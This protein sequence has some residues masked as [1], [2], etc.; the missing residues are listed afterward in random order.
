[1]RPPSLRSLPPF[2]RSVARR[3][4]LS[5]GVV[6]IDGTKVH[7]N[8]SRDANRSYAQ[9]AREILADAAETDRRE[10]ELYGDARGDELP[11]QLRT[12]AGR[13]AALRE[14][15]ERIEQEG[16]ADG[17]PGAAEQE[18]LPPPEDATV[19]IELDPAR[20][21]TRPEGRRA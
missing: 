1:M 10:D 4:L 8:A 20:F 16:S 12:S 7:A 3:G 2:S 17:E 14:A 11:E 15:K 9:I 6:E 5:V 19:A 18:T 21:V 13:K